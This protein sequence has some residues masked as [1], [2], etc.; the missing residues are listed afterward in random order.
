[1]QEAGVEEAKRQ[2]VAKLRGWSESSWGW[3][4]PREVQSEFSEEKRSMKF[5]G[6]VRVR[7]GN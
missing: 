5:R 4:S 6:G 7:E 2:Q 3:E 1:M